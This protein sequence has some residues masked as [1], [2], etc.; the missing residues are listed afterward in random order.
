MPDPHVPE[1]AR[2]A[3]RASL[4]WSLPGVRGERFRRGWWDAYDEH[5]NADDDPDYRAGRTEYLE[6]FAPP[7]AQ[8]SDPMTTETT[9]VCTH[10]EDLPLELLDHSTVNPRK[11]FDAQKLAEL[12]ASVVTNGVLHPILARPR[13]GGRFEV[14]AGERRLRAA[15]AAKL[16][17]IP[18]V[19]RE[20][21]DGQALEAAIV[22]NAQRDD[23]PPIEEAEGYRRLRD[24]RKLTPEEIAA[25]VGKSITLVF[26]RLRLT[27]LVEPA[28][29]L[30]REGK[31]YLVVAEELARLPDVEAQTAAL[32]ELKRCGQQPVGV[33]EAR[34][35]ILSYGTRQ[36]RDAPFDQA[37]A[38]LVPAAG[39]CTTCPHR[40]G[41][42]LALFSDLSEDTCTLRSCWDRKV[43][44][45]A[46]RAK[47]EWE[48]KGVKPLSKTER[49]Q[50]FPDWAHDDVP[51]GS[52]YCTLDAP[53]D[54]NTYDQHPKRWRD[55]FKGDDAP[56]PAATGQA[57]SGAVVPLWT[58]KQLGDEAR[59]RGVKLKTARAGASLRSDPTPAD[60][61]KA[62]EAKVE[63]ATATA[64]LAA[65]A[66]RA[67]SV[68]SG[69]LIQEALWPILADAAIDN[70]WHDA[71]KRV[72][73]RRE[74]LGGKGSTDVDGT[75]RKYLKDASTATARGL[76]LEL[77]AAHAIAQGNYNGGKI[78]GVCKDLAELLEVD[79]TKLRNEAKT[80][81]SPKP[82]H[83][84]AHRRIMSGKPKGG[85]KRSKRRK[86]PWANMTPADKNARVA[87]ML[88]GGPRKQA[89]DAAAVAAAQDAEL[90]TDKVLGPK[91]GTKSG[92]KKAR[93]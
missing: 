24:E 37:A 51:K 9:P 27:E 75:L 49:A 22:E 6:H 25:R 68:A 93:E 78:H 14:V 42:A 87:R 56:P 77:F 4:F 54:P 32:R 10:V 7:G 45:S 82:D 43:A 13:P 92:T 38:N 62:L 72:A 12:T 91:F 55:V 86:N 30:L 58:R 85:G 17:T 59:R 47:E 41:N 31:L 84:E 66:D 80:R 67:L 74:L 16:P 76:A 19:I 26:R 11:T 2:G 53:I 46:M 15:A 3:V 60:R 63:S 35:I 18:V 8:E 61:R 39:P 36:L 1:N 64:V 73:A 71:R 81:L 44:A 48:A 20:M 40:A 21:D 50:V 5:P 29:D 88:A 33:T 70:V 79:V 23:V 34:R 52:T 90:A 57:P 89:S 69:S 28:Q 83:A 65:I